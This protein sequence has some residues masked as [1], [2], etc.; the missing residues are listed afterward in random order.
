[1]SS[2]RS[3]LRLVA[4]FAMTVTLAQ[5]QFFQQSAAKIGKLT[6][7]CPLRGTWREAMHP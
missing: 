1:M 5:A 2:A 4:T 3:A 7:T 6:A